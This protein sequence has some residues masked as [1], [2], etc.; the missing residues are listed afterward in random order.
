[1]C[2]LAIF[3]RAVDRAPLL[4]AA[5]REEFFDRPFL[6]PY[7]QGDRTRFLAGVDVRAGGTWLGMNERGMMAAVTNRPKIALPDQPR[8]R[9]LLCRELLE[10]PSVA[11]AREFIQQELT[12]GAYAGANFVVADARDGIL[13]EAG[14]ELSISWL[15]PGLH[16]VTNGP[17]NSPLDPRQLLAREMFAAASPRDVPSFLTTARRVCS[18]GPDASGRSIVLRRPE[19]GTVSSTVLALTTDPQEAICEFAAGSPDVTPY[20]DYSQELRKLL[21]TA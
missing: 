6:P 19:R 21:N 20:K 16:L 5:N 10:Q 13:V 11:S 17:A 18:Q 3:H 7:V 8:S 4:V 14:D 2:L 15:V 9:G 12:T 1:M